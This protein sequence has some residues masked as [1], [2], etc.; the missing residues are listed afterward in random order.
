MKMI[1]S[2]HQGVHGTK[3]CT[4]CLTLKP[5]FI[6]RFLPLLEG[7][8]KSLVGATENNFQKFNFLPREKQNLEK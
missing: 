6:Q 3:N 7:F 1:L 4:E 5:D 2:K 8:L